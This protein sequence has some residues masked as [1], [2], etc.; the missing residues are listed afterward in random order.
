MTKSKA[1]VSKSEQFLHITI[2][3]PGCWC[4]LVG[5]C[6]QIPVLCYSLTF[7]EQDFPPVFI[8]ASMLCRTIL[9]RLVR[10]AV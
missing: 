5:N 8:G 6:G 10:G 9:F 3:E 4:C 1:A 7:L 2:K